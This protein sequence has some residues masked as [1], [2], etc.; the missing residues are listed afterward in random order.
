MLGV[1]VDEA[2]D[3]GGGLKRSC[4]D[5][6]MDGD[7]AGPAASEFLATERPARDTSALRTETGRAASERGLA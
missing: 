3:H 2:L 1:D 5:M 4:P 7:S 6:V